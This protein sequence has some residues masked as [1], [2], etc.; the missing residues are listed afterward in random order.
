MMKPLAQAAAYIQEKSNLVPKVGIVLGTGLGG[1]AEQVTAEAVLPYADIP[2]FPVSTAPDHAGRMRLGRLAGVPVCVLE[3]RVHY[4]EGYSMQEVAFPVRVLRLLGAE[5][6]ILTNAVG[7]INRDYRVGDLMLIRDHIKFFND[8]PLR[9][10]NLDAL[11]PR[12]SDMCNAYPA[13]LRTLARE[14]QY[15]IG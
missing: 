15:P 13:R 9:G 5:T 8:T 14:S 3:G 10:P 2:N 11:G 12:F 6:V 1:L 7:G 4:Y